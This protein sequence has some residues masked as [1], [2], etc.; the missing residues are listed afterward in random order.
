[1]F[2]AIVAMVLVLLLVWIVA[3]VDVVRAAEMDQTS[4]LILAAVLLFAAPLG[5]LVWMVVRGGRIGAV[6]AAAVA[7]VTVFVVAGVAYS[8]TSHSGGIH[9]VEVTGA[10]ASFSASDGGSGQPIP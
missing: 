4:R 8:I 6:A 9:M 3:L 1:M 5:V 10:S 7:A 2:A